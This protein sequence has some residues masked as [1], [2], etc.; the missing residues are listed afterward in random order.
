VDG[1]NVL[2][3]WR[4]AWV[5][6]IANIYLFSWSQ[7]QLP[8]GGVTSEIVCVGLGVKPSEN[9]TPVKLLIWG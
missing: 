6:E 7:R 5:Q 3:R 8:A 4:L 2:W 9:V 1:S